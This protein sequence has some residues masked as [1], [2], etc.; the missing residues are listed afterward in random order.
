MSATTPNWE[1]IPRP[2][3]RAAVL[4]DPRYQPSRRRGASLPELDEHR[5]SCAAIAS[6]EGMPSAASSAAVAPSA[7]DDVL[8]R[9]SGPPAR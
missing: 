8:A 3:V 5:V 7:L 2:G 9:L 1:P 4:A 6:D